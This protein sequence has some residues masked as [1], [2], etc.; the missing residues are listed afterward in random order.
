MRT[1]NLKAWKWGFLLNGQNGQY[2]EVSAYRREEGSS[3]NSSDHLHV[4]REYLFLIKI[5]LRYW[6]RF[7]FLTKEFDF[8][9]PRLENKGNV[10]LGF[11]FGLMLKS[12][13]RLN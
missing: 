8:F 7:L 9:P 4:F 1:R 10:G 2:F 3:E 11:L 13:M 12:F 6:Q 5:E